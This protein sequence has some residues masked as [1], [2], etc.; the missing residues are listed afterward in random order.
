MKF[1]IALFF[2]LTSSSVLACQCE[3]DGMELDPMPVVEKLLKKSLGDTI[4]M[5]K[6]EYGYP[7]SDWIKAYPSIL[8]RLFAR[9]YIGS[10]CESR[11]PNNELLMPC[12]TKTKDDYRYYLLKADGKECTATVQEKVSPKNVKV[13][14]LSTTCR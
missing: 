13:K 7:K 12:P 5:Q 1:Y 10:S 6:D 2:I 11:G 9:E 4:T 14:L 8:D 3:S